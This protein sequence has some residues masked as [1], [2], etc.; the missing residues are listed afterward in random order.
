MKKFTCKVCGYVIKTDKP[1]ERC[2]V[3]GAGKKYFE[4]KK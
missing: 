3:C 4:E 2:P 1:P